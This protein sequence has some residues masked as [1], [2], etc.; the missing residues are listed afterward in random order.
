M[1]SSTTD[2]CAIA[3]PS[4]ETAES[5]ETP[6]KRR[7]FVVDDHPIFR[8]GIVQVINSEPDF[9]VCGEAN[10]A[11]EALAAL[12]E[13]A[14]DIAVL[15][16]SLQGCNGI[17]LIKHLAAEHPKLPMLVLSMHDERHYAVRALRAGAN[18]YVMKREHVDNFIT[19]LRRVLE[20][21]IYV[22]DALGEQLI[23][24]AL[25]GNTTEASSP[26]DLLSDREV[27]ILQLVGQGRSSRDIADQLHLSTKTVESHRLRMKEKLGLKNASELVRFAMNWVEEQG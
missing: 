20:G 8:H 11:S 18:G 1:T 7:V 3:D 24:Q 21:K 26:V 27:E 13:I 2:T 15:D 6:T 12:R 17:E 23:F 14:V 25:R 19:A 16:I 5:A 4:L 22:S 10:S 9:D